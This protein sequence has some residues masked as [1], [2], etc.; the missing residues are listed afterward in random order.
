MALTEKKKLFGRKAFEIHTGISDKSG[1]QAIRLSLVAAAA[2]G[3]SVTI[4][5]E[6]WEVLANDLENAA[7]ALRLRFGEAATH[8]SPD[9][10]SDGWDD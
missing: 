9:V 2:K 10:I 1:N 6:R 8:S 3:S 5:A 7:A 4:N